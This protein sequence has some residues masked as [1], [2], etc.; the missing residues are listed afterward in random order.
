MSEMMNIIILC[1][2]GDLL[3]SNYIIILKHL[4]LD[5]SIAAL[6][7]TGVLKQLYRSDKV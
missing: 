5:F 1:N 7:G 4:I 3:L 2:F 6:N